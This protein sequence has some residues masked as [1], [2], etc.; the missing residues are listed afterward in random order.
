MEVNIGILSQVLRGDLNQQWC[1]STEWQ[2]EQV[3]SKK[4][5]KQNGH[6]CIESKETSDISGIDNKD[7]VIGEFDTYRTVLRQEK[8]MGRI[9][10]LL[11]E[12]V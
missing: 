12:P 7:R 9:S 5:G 4:N 6:L 3:S 1:S 2:M 10:H 8:K 11:N